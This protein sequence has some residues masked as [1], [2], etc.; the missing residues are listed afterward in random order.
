MTTNVGMLDRLLRIVIG[1]AL[2]AFALG[3][4]YPATGWNWVG[5]IGIVPIAT[6]L[7]GYC[8][9]YTLFGVSSRAARSGP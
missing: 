6:A 3:Y 2:L 9:A 1:F 4:F 5:W 7:F 8:P